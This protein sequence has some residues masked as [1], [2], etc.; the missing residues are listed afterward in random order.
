MAA[1]AVAARDIYNWVRLN[2]AGDGNCFYRS[3]YQ[4]ARL[5]LDPAVLDELFR[6][7]GVRR[8]DVEVPPAALPPPAAAT[9]L[10]TRR[11]IR[12]SVKGGTL[13]ESIKAVK[14]AEDRFC[15][16]ARSA[17]AAKVRDASGAFLDTLGNTSPYNALIDIK[18]Q[19]FELQFSN[20]VPIIDALYKTIEAELEAEGATHVSN[21]VIS[22]LLLDTYS[23]YFNSTTPPAILERLQLQ[24]ITAY[25]RLIEN[26]PYVENDDFIQPSYHLRRDLTLGDFPK[27]L[28]KSFKEMWEEFLG[29][30]SFGF[31]RVF[32]D[33]TKFPKSRAEF[34]PKYAT[35]LEKYGEFTT[36]IDMTVINAILAPCNLRVHVLSTLGR[37]RV[38]NPAPIKPIYV[39]LDAEGEHYNFLIAPSK[40]EVAPAEYNLYGGYVPKPQFYNDS[41]LFTADSVRIHGDSVAE[42]RS[43]VKSTVRVPEVKAN[44]K[45]TASAQNSNNEY[46]FIDNNS[47]LNIIESNNNNNDQNNNANINA[48]LANLGLSP[49]DP[50]Y[51]SARAALKLSKYGGSKKRRVTRKKRRV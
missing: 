39:M 17:I 18:N 26:T 6:C 12:R 46:E 10:P 47:N 35:L 7:I 9:S 38:E 43:R 32:R 2:V 3:L 16:L 8:E 31:Q 4:A 44:V 14:E 51:N 33:F 50:N 19:L 22:A 49:S 45:S 1:A 27:S 24:A 25:K 23:D 30:M 20:P 21:D 28:H 40:Y 29:S 37:R 11:I 36:E 42:V 34:A 41:E 13:Q 5:H 15:R 48:Q